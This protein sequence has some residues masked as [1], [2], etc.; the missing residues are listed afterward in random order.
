MAERSAYEMS[1]T[2]ARENGIMGV[3]MDYLYVDAGL[4]KTSAY[5]YYVTIRSLAKFLFHERYHMDCEPDEVVLSTVSA[6]DFL[7]I[8]ETEWCNYL[9]YCQYTN[10]QTDGSFAVRISVIRG[11]YQWLQ[12]ETNEAVPI[13]I[14]ATK[15][16]DIPVPSD[17]RIVTRRMADQLCENME[18]ENAL[19]N[20]C[21]V[22]LCLVTG[23]G[24]SDICRLNI[25]DVNLRSITIC[26][27]S[28]EDVHDIPID[29][30]M[31][32]ILSS[33]IAER[34]PPTDGSNALFV[35]ST[36]GRMKRG[37]VEKMLRKAAAKGGP[38]TRGITTRDLRLTGR[39][40][41]VESHGLKDAEAFTT[42]QSKDYF[43]R[44]FKHAPFWLS[45]PTVCSEDAVS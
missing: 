1:N 2:Y 9:D 18:G 7:T 17:F 25:E 15:R 22:R 41:L 31:S 38:L 34:R 16:P 42:V 45:Q 11:F 36:A 14:L 29:D 23:I 33:Y 32:Q 3:Y 6:S 8:S 19:R 44:V 30:E 37:A 40:H 35:S 10:K 43:R 12:T 39:M 24:L 13:F 20:I 28:G 26:D 27:D 21:I 4:A 5:N